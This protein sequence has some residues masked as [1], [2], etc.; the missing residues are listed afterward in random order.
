MTQLSRFTKNVQKQ[1]NSFSK[2]F[3][4]VLKSANSLS[5]SFVLK[6]SIF[7]K[8]ALH[9]ITKSQT[10]S[11]CWGQAFFSLTSKPLETHLIC[12]NK[13]INNSIQKGCMEKVAGCWENLSIVWHALK[14]ARTQKST[15]AT[16]WLDIAIGVSPQWIRLVESYYKRMFSKLFCDWATSAWNSQ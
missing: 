3:K 6:R 10:F 13:S 4:L 7:L 8:T 2:F 14:E 12:N 1:V 16:I 15:L 5:N 9:L 11:Q